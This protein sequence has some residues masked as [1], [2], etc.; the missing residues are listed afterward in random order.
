ML[1]S[2]VSRLT[3]GSAL[4]LAIVLPALV[5]GCGGG[6]GGGSTTLIVSGKVV[7]AGTLNPVQG[8]LVSAQGQTVTTAGD[9]TFT[10]YNLA[11]NPVVITFGA[12]AYQ[13]LQQTISVPGGGVNIGSVALVPAHRAGTGNVTGTV[14]VNGLAAAGASITG[15]G[16]SARSNASGQFTLY[17]ATPGTQTLTGSTSGGAAVGFAQVVVPADST[18]SGVLLAITSGPPPPPAPPPVI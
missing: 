18:L 6:G 2:N 1:L 8:A 16:A 7:N 13:T 9:G 5:T 12:A 4:L 14:T 15:A 11:H 17:N 3:L 10:L